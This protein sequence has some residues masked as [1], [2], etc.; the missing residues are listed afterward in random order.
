MADK[1]F[2]FFEL[3]LHDADVQFG[4]ESIGSGVLGS[5]EGD[6][7]ETEPTGHDVEVA[8]SEGGGAGTAVAALVVLVAVAA[9][10]YAAKK[11]LGGDDELAEL[12]ELDGSP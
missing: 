9:L 8:A 2:T 10:V 12:E 5:D 7:E 3:H 6:S 4:P 1:E 11:L